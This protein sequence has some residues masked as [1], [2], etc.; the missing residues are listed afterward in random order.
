M[1][2]GMRAISGVVF[3]GAAMSFALAQTVTVYDKPN[4]QGKSL[5]ISENNWSSGGAGAAWNDNIKSVKVPSGWTVKLY[6]HDKTRGKT[7]TITA[8]LPK[9]ADGFGIS[10]IEILSSPKHAC[11]Y[12]DSKDWSKWTKNGGFA[13]NAKT[14]DDCV[15][16]DGCLQGGGNKSNGGC[17]VYASSP[18]A[19]ANLLKTSRKK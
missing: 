16:W 3:L 7:E 6:E 13:T 19:A 11:Y 18:D 12:Q 17:Y 2:Y 1:L 8:D 5:Q 15:A 9:I 4:F 14:F 10:N